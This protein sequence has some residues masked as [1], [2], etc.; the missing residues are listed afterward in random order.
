[1]Q[2]LYFG[3]VATAFWVC[4]TASVYYYQAVLVIQRMLTAKVR[5]LHNAKASVG[6][7]HG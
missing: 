6:D 7:T 4:V 3:C 2:Y 1:M 5:G